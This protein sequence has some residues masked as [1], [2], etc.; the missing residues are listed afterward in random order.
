MKKTLISLCAVVLV[1]AIVLSLWL[2]LKPEEIN[3]SFSEKDLI[4]KEYFSSDRLYML[5]ISEREDIQS[6]AISN[7]NG[8]YAFVYKVTHNGETVN[9]FMIEGY[10]DFVFDEYLFSAILS[11]T[12]LTESLSEIRGIF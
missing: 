12:V 1:I 4:N 9:A 3:N 8:D 10:E 11:Y 5:P 2:C 7:E 6:I